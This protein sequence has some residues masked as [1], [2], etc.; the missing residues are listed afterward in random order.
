MSH[1]YHEFL[2]S[3]ANLPNLIDGVTEPQFSN[4][5]DEFIRYRNIE[6]PIALKDAIEFQYTYWPQPSNYSFIRKKLIEVFWYGKD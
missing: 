1:W 6:K 4:I 3:P 2:S 5:I